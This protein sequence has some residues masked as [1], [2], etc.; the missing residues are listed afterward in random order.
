MTDQ[1]YPILKC[2]DDGAVFNLSGR[3]T[4][5]GASASC[6]IKLSGPAPER[7]AHI[8]F[9]NGRY[10]LQALAGAHKVKLNGKPLKLPADLSHGDNIRLINTDYL[11]LEKSEKEGVTTSPGITSPIGELIDV[12]VSLL[13]DRSRDVFQELVTSI[14]RLLKCDAA[15][16]L[17]QE[18]GKEST[19]AVASFPSGASAGRFSNRAISWARDSKKTVLMQDSD[20]MENGESMSSLNRNAVGSVLCAPLLSGGDL[21]GFLYLDRLQGNNPFSEDDRE[22][23][24]SLRPLLENILGI[25]EAHKRQKDTIARLQQRDIPTSSGII[26][27]SRV[28]EKTLRMAEK[29]ARTNTPIFIYGETGTG[30]E[31][32]SKYIHENSERAGGPFVA[33]NCGAIPENL[34]ESELFGHEKGAFTGAHQQKIGYFEKANGGTLFLDEIGELPLSLQ[35]KL[36]RVL[37]ESEV[38]RVGGTTSIPINLR[39]LSA[40]NRN[41]YQEVSEGRFREDLF[42]RLNVININLP[43]LRD[44]DS[45]VLLIAD[46]FLHKYCQQFGMSLKKLDASARASLMEYPW[47]GNIRELE[48]V[49]QKS[50]LLTGNEKISGED[51]NIDTSPFS[52]GTTNPVGHLTLKE[53][54]VKA[55]TEIITSVLKKWNGNVSRTA[56]QLDIDRTWLMKLMK[57]YQI[58]PDNFRQRS[59]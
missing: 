54:R 12:I 10:N 25:K 7:L 15:R 19:R 14:S 49:T 27:S 18:A 29:V 53:A 26:Y 2:K 36:L 4:T 1:S 22:F 56:K 44:R 41:L 16:L 13:E 45:D 38:V 9:K 30:K 59:H 21:I 46:F 33:V 24:D 23:C 17:R 6:N 20:W 28:M 43:P 11:F 34:I 8:L 31:L 3:V 40:S 47:P 5:A 51:I 52:T 39:I 37:Q 55:E 42:F 35:V 58:N 32:V 57:E 48:N 50:I